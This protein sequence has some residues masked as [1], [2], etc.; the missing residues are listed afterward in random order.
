MTAAVVGELAAG[1]T[2]ERIANCNLGALRVA[3]AVHLR[4]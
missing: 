1:V 3:Q 4:P 2:T